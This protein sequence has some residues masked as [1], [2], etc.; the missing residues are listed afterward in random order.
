MAGESDRY[1]RWVKSLPCCSCGARGPS[2]PHHKPRRYGGKR[3]H[4]FTAIS[5]CRRCHD[6][7]QHP[8]SLRGRFAGWTREQ[9]DTWHERQAELNRAHWFIAHPKHQPDPSFPMPTREAF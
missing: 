5:L 6:D 2:D 1:R 9:Y 7:C 3:S 4:D 8:A